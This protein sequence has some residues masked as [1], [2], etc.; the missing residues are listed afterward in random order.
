MLGC[1]PGVALQQAQVPALTSAPPARSDL[2]YRLP[3]RLRGTAGPRLR[4]L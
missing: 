1:S 3:Y 4:V 2:P